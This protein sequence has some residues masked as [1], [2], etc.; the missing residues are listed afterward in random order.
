M[1]EKELW[2]DRIVHEL[3]K[4][5]VEELRAFWPR[6]EEAMKRMNLPA[7]AREY[8]HVAVTLVIEKKLEK[9]RS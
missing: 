1:K 7:W 4:M 9:Q 3:G 8:G 6:W 2:T 5:S